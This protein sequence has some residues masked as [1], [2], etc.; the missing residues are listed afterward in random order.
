MFGICDLLPIP[1]EPYFVRSI[2]IRESLVMLTD[3]ICVCDQHQAD[4]I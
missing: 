4:N 1:G 2:F 3:S